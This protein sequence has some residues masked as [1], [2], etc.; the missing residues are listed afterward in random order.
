MYKNFIAIANIGTEYIYK[1]NSAIAV[2][3][4]SAQKIAEALTRAAYKLETGETWHVYETEYDNAF[5]EVRKFNGK[6][7]RIH[8]R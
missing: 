7:V 2:P 5:Y 1:R 6:Y 3:A 4:K 8:E